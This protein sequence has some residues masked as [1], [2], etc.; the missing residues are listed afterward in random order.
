MSAK[1]DNSF[2]KPSSPSPSRESW[3]RFSS[4]MASPLWR[5]FTSPPHLMSVMVLRA[6]KTGFKLSCASRPM[7]PMTTT[8]APSFFRKSRV[9]KA[10]SNRNVSATRPSL[11][12][13]FKEARSNTRL[14]LRSLT[15]RID[16]KPPVVFFELLENQLS[17][18]CILIG[19]LN[20]RNEF[21]GFQTGATD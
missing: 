3:R 10:C 20:Y 14:P 9:G 1:A 17:H 13:T 18:F 4:N 7:C 12:G 15:S 19:N 11:I 21:L 5:S 16:G 6:S 8:L 2:E